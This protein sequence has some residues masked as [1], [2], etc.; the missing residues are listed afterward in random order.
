MT[1]TNIPSSF[2]VKG[3][4]TPEFYKSLAWYEKQYNVSIPMNHSY[5]GY[6]FG[7]N[8]GKTDFW[9]GESVP[10][11]VSIYSPTEFMKLVEGGEEERVDKGYASSGQ[12]E[13]TVDEI[14]DKFDFNDKEAAELRKLAKPVVP[15]THIVGDIDAWA[16]AAGYVKL[17]EWE[18]VVRKDTMSEVLRCVAAKPIDDDMAKDLGYIKLEPNQSVITWVNTKDR[19]PV[20]G[21]NYMTERGPMF[22][23]DRNN[24]WTVIGSSGQTEVKQWADLQLPPFKEEPIDYSKCD[25]EVYSSDGNW[26]PF[27]TENMPEN[28]VEA[29]MKTPHFRVKAKPHPVKR[30]G[31]VALWGKGNLY[32]V[33]GPHASELDAM[34]QTDTHTAPFTAI[35]IEWTEQP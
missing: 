18:T 13:M 17:Q 19:N 8:N 2:A 14:V 27:G 7:L 31:W 21:G 34:S 1:N 35:E 24:Y 33:T 12:Q 6:Y 5:N 3:E 15:V 32:Q 26:H 9:V 16:K 29:L 23:F 30:R 4:D 20:M 10:G 11:S 28:I 25:F 22:Y